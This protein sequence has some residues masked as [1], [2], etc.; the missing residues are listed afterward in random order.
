MAK[1]AEK[2]TQVRIDPDVRPMIKRA[3]KKKRSRSATAEVNSVLRSE[4][5]KPCPNPV[6]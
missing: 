5:Q 3:M 2:L 6:N 4:Y 1:A